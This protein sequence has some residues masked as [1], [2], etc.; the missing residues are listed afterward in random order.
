MRAIAD[1]SPI[2]ARERLVSGLA[3]DS[4]KTRQAS[5]LDRIHARLGAL[6]AL[7][8]KA[9]T[10]SPSSTLAL[11]QHPPTFD[12][13]VDPALLAQR[14]CPAP[15]CCRPA[16]FKVRHSIRGAL[17][18]YIL[19]PPAPDTMPR[20]TAS[21]PHAPTA[22]LPQDSCIRL[23]D[24]DSHNPVQSP[25]LAS[26]LAYGVL[27]SETQYRQWRLILAASRTSGG[28]YTTLRYTLP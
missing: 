5:S 28:P 9:S 2:N 16:L 8:S 20:C 23:P 17:N 21:S 3:G 12:S 13:A 10:T 19:P 24:L 7:H 14:L 6:H 18:P 25:A 11:R 27:L 22:W 26:V 15:L 1:R 4:A